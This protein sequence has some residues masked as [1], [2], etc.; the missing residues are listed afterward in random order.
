MNAVVDIKQTEDKSV[1]EVLSDVSTENLTKKK[2]KFDYL[3]WAVAWNLLLQY[4]PD[5]THEILEFD[6]LPYLKTENGYF[7]KT[8]VTIENTT[9]TQMHPVLSYNNKPHENPSCFE[10]NTSH[11]RCLAKNIGLFG[12]GLHLYFEE[13]FAEQGGDY[14]TEHKEEFDEA[15][16]KRDSL[17]LVCLRNDIGMDAYFALY[18]SFPRGQKTTMKELAGELENEGNP[19]FNDV[20]ENMQSLIDSNDSHGSR[21][22]W[23]ELTKRQKSATYKALND[24]EQ[25][26]LKAILEETKD[27]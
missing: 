4:Y 17:T 15:L 2:G 9:R 5:S 13:E 12:L 16:D 21:E 14:T 10:I 24:H 20:V 18:N 26:K 8:S 27:E 23:D 3:P 11:R 6:G 1:Y 7:V 25:E 19:K 22:S